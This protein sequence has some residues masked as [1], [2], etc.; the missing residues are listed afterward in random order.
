MLHS[1]RILGLE[2][3][4][5]RVLLSISI[6]LAGS[7]GD[8]LVSSH[9]LVGTTETTEPV[10]TTNSNSGAKTIPTSDNDS[11]YSSSDTTSGEASDGTSSSSGTGKNSS[12]QQ[13]SGNDY[14]ESGSESSTNN[15]SAGNDST[16]GEYYPS[17]TGTSGQTG[18]PNANQ[19]QADEYTSTQSSENRQYQQDEEYS[20][21]LSVFFPNILSPSL[22]SSATE[23]NAAVAHSSSIPIQ[24]ASR[25]SSTASSQPAIATATS[26]FLTTDHPRENGSDFVNIISNVNR[27]TRPEEN[28]PADSI[29]DDNINNLVMPENLTVHIDQKSVNAAVDE[30]LAGLDLVLQYP[31]NAESFWIRLGYWVVAVSATVVGY[32]LMRQDFRRQRK[33]RTDIRLATHTS[34]Y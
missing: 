8:S 26:G 6:S 22:I 20:R 2:P 16:T 5:D 12:P 9:A 10:N 24:A 13:T 19:T 21:N 18:T 27:Y 7:I 4:E 23:P 14:S 11:E 15:V 32:E 33:T 34:E 31:L 17:G 28:S 30:L 25:L 3:L 1:P 29:T